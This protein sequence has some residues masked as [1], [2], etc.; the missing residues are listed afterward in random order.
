MKRQFYTLLFIILLINNF[1]SVFAQVDIKDSTIFTPIISFHFSFQI[2]G[3]DLAKRFGSNSNVGGSFMIKNKNNWLFG[4]DYNF[5]FG[6]IIKEDTILKMISTKA[7]SIIGGDG[8]FASVNQFERGFYADLKLGKIFSF[9]KPNPNSGVLVTGSVGFLEHKVRTEVTDNTAPQL[10]G[11]YK[12]GY[13]R[14]TNGVGISEFIGYLYLGNN[15]LTSFYAGFEFIQS[16]T[17]SKRKW[18]FDRMGADNSKR[19]DTLYGIKVGWIIPLYKR[20][21]KTGYYYF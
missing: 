6:N 7:G 14:L 19:F 20:A 17:R 15:R 2:P 18:D 1:E 4:A 16:W 8:I 11:D 12:K 10:M 5:L 3:N 9:K 13:D 21:S